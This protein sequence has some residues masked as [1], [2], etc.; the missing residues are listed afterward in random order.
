MK[1]LIKLTLTCSNSSYNLDIEYYDIIRED[2]NHI[3]YSHSNF[4]FLLSKHS[5]LTQIDKEI[6]KHSISVE[7]HCLEHQIEEAKELLMINFIKEINRVLETIKAIEEQ[8]ML[9]LDKD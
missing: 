3:Y 9:Y 4:Y 2:E 7:I 6:K 8:F 1:K 5:L